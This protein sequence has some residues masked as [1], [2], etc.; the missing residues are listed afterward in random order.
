MES[1]LNNGPL[2][3][4]STKV[5]MIIFL[6][7]YGVLNHKRILLLR[8]RGANVEVTQTD[9]VIQKSDMM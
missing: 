8:N 4:N 1:K 7:E 2:L 9:N 3:Y 5:L 6:I